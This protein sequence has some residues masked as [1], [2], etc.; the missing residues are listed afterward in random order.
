MIYNHVVLCPK[1]VFFQV[2]CVAIP[3]DEEATHISLIACC[4]A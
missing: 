2:S 1:M 4:Y 3:V